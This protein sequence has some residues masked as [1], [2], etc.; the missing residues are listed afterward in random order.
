MS[1]DAILQLLL[2]V[3]A[4]VVL[5][6]PLGWYM[7]Q[8]YEQK[9]CGLDW[10]CLPIERFIY[11]ICHIHPDNEVSWKGYLTSML[12]FNLSG[13]LA[14]YFILR[15]Q[16]YLPLNPQAFP[17]IS[18]DLAFNTAASYVANTNWQAYDPESSISYF[19]Q[20][21][22]LTVQNSS[23]C[24]RHVITHGFDTRHSQT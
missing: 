7:A 5:V 14:V 24:N 13:L 6:K 20:M 21:L 15:F 22:A 8:V 23:C 19:T 9:P 12:I 18:P 11:R 2:Y 3:L 1:N 4:I 10:L 16:F 17:G